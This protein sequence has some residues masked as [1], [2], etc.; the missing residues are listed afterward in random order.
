MS[1]MDRM[2]PHVKRSH[3]IIEPYFNEIIIEDQNAF[4]TQEG[5]DKLLKMIFDENMRKDV[6]QKLAPHQG[7]LVE[8]LK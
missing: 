6:K 7:I 4:G 5:V 3:K 2:H 8:S 1:I